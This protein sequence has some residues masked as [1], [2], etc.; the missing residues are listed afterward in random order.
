ML[1]KYYYSVNIVIRQSVCLLTCLY[2]SS[3]VYTECGQIVGY[4]F[5]L[6]V[7]CIYADEKSLTF[8]LFLDLSF[9]VDVGRYK[10]YE[11]ILLI[12]SVM[13]SILT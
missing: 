10:M 2:F 13:F 12:D 9:W 6:C 11:Y 8:S 3:S 5:R 4:C 1:I 7:K